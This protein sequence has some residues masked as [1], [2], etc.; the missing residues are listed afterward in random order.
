MI[1]WSWNFQL[2]ACVLFLRQ[3][4]KLVSAAFGSRFGSRLGFISCFSWF[5]STGHVRL[6]R[7]KRNNKA[8]KEGGVDPFRRQVRKLGINAL[9]ALAG[10]FGWHHRR[11][12]FGF[13]RRS[14]VDSCF[15]GNALIVLCTGIWNQWRGLAVKFV[16]PLG[17]VRGGGWW[18]PAAQQVKAKLN[19]SV[20]ACC[21]PLCC[22]GFATKRVSPACRSGSHETTMLL[23]VPA[24]NAG[25]KPMRRQDRGDVGGRISLQVFWRPAACCQQ[26]VGSHSMFCSWFLVARLRSE[27]YSPWMLC[28]S[29]WL[30]YVARFASSQGQG[31]GWITWIGCYHK[32][33]NRYIIYW[34]RNRDMR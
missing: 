25:W 20:D 13:S 22:F 29:A 15:W 24:H 10:F 26:C 33:T 5:V 6:K 34:Y 19:C 28:R 3:S 8:L 23:E 21:R 12:S 1:V 32:E 17:C 2:Q 4:M 7:T 30:V 16:A 31:M 14:C 11:C 27:I 9:K 18:A